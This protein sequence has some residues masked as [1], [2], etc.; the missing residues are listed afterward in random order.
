[1]TIDWLK[2]KTTGQKFYPVTHE[3]A[4]IDSNGVTLSTK[5]EGLE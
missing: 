5:L 3:D 2:D 4:V 1:M